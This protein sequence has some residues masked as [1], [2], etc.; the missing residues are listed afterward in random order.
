MLSYFL[1]ERLQWGDEHWKKIF[2]HA[3]ENLIKKNILRAGFEPATYGLL[4]FSNYSPPL[5]Q[6]S[7]RRCDSRRALCTRSMLQCSKW[8]LCPLSFFIPVLPWWT[9]IQYV[10]QFEI[11]FRYTGGV[12]QMVERSLSMRE[13]PGSIPGASKIFFLSIFMLKHTLFHGK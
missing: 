9:I 7:Y 11:R 8:P 5:Y 4:P 10:V 13:V 2:C 1:L 12:A 3:W 6:L